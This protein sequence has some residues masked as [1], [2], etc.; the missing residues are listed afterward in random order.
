MLKGSKA[1]EPVTFSSL[2]GKT[3]G[4]GHSIWLHW[5][6]ENVAVVLAC[7]IIDTSIVLHVD[8]LLVL[9]YSWNITLLFMME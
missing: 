9:L 2:N 4:I 1:V 3:V 8:V 7:C 6:C 5:L